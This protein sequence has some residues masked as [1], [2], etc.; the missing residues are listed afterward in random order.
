MA[1]ARRRRNF[2]SNLTIRDVRLSK[3]E[4]LRE[5]IGSYFKSLF[6]EPQMRRPDV[7]SSLFK[8]LAALDNETL[9]GP[10]SKEEVS[11]S[12][13]YLGVIRRQGRMVFRSGSF[14]GL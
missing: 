13:S 14:V 2:I 4:E 8:T 3:E 11:K 1:N 5:G 10:F 9:E 12:L 7:E 6:E